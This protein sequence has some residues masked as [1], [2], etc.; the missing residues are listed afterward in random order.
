MFDVLNLKMRAKRTNCARLNALD[1]IGLDWYS[2]GMLCLCDR[3]FRCMFKIMSCDC[4][5]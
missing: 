2:V 3:C 5:S 1:C 4:Y